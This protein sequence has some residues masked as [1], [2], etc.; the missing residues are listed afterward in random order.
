M[1]REVEYK[2]QPLSFVLDGVTAVCGTRN[3]G[4]EC[5]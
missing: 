1:V 2:D 5:R 3:V 4:V